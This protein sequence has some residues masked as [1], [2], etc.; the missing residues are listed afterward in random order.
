MTVFVVTREHSDHSGYEVLRVT[1]TRARANEDL[2][3]VVGDHGMTYRIHEVE[4]IIGPQ[5]HHQET[6]Q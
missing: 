3:L 4:L 6:E 1:M 5:Q 2:A